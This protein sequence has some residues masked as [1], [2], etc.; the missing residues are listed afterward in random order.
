AA[1]G[2]RTASLGK[3]PVS[4]YQIAFDETGERFLAWGE[5]GMLEVRE[6]STGRRLGAMGPSLAGAFAYDA[7]RDLV[8]CT[9]LEGGLRVYQ[10]SMC[11][12]L[13]TIP[14]PPEDVNVLAFA[15]GGRMVYAA[16][17]DG[18]VRAYSLG[19]GKTTVVYRRDT[20]I[21]GMALSPDGRTL[22]VPG[23]DR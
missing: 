20:R 17:A 5:H 7:A 4:G 19:D 8:A 14:G 3:S 15:P 13:R 2:R 18:T 10:P 21:M 23:T 16:S 12:L 22:V 1:T 11:K 6:T 9:P